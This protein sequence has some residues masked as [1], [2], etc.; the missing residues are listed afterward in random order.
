MYFDLE[1]AAEAEEDFFT[2]LALL[3]STDEDSADKLRQMLDAS[4]VKKHG[5]D[6]SLAVRMRR[7]SLSL[8]SEETCKNTNERDINIDGSNGKGHAFRRNVK[9]RASSPSVEVVTAKIG[10][11]MTNVLV[12]V[13][14]MDIPTISIPDEGSSAGDDALCKIC[15]GARLGPLILLECQE[16]QDVYHP[17]CHQPPVLD[18]D[19]Y[20][21][22][23][24]WH[25]AKCVELSEATA[26]IVA[27][28][29]EDKKFQ[30]DE[31]RVDTRFD[32]QVNYF[33][34][35]KT[36]LDGQEDSISDQF[37]LRNTPSIGRLSAKKQTSTIYHNKSH[38]PKYLGS[39]LY[40]ENVDLAIK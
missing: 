20:D 1:N 3:H 8:F 5:L 19:I 17:L 23:L 40:R 7:D 9:T 34:R 33:R 38:Y 27:A 15:N 32:E 36:R 16:C 26:I 6:K 2:A 21:P 29:L 24:V 18:L 10:S 31:E 4:I 14:K 30:V 11:S 28:G 39:I 13:D 25:C 35:T 37:P 12:A 22:R